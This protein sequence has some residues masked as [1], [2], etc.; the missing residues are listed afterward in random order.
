[1]NKKSVSAENRRQVIERAAGGCEYCRSNSK[2]SDTPFD[3]EH[4]L[5]E[6]KGGKSELPNLALA[7]HGCNFYKSNKTEFFDAVIDKNVRIFHPR[8]DAWN[9]HFIW[10]SDFTEIVG[11]TAVGRATIDALNLNREGL[12]NQRQLLYKYGKPPPIQL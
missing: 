9:E 11:L 7:C 1:M 5:P 3:V 10:T 12:I 8:T 4:I 2:F 6:S